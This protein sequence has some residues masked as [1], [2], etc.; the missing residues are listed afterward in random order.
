M[1]KFSVV[2]LTAALV[3]GASVLL[4]ACEGG[5]VDPGHNDVS[6]FDGSGGSGPDGSGRPDGGGGG[7]KPA[8]LSESA[9][10][11]EAIAKLDEILSY[12][13]TSSAIKV[14]VR[15]LKMGLE[16]ISSAEWRSTRMTHIDSIN[17]IIDTL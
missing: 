13:G 7:G 9:T 4:I 3:L 2:L 6:G 1:R 11:D 17:S 15:Q 10:R 12:S 8:K 5:F 14:G 16:G